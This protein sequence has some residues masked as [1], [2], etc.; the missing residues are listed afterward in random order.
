MQVCQLMPPSIRLLHHSK[1]GSSDLTDLLYHINESAQ[2]IFH[3]DTLHRSGESTVLK[4][5][6]S[7]KQM[8]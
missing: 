6:Y 4:L 2:N 8:H 3:V 7:P 1:V 5:D